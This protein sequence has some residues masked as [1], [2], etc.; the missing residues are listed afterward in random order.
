MGVVDAS[1]GGKV[2]LFLCVEL[3]VGVVLGGKFDDGFLRL[4][5]RLLLDELYVFFKHFN[6]FLNTVFFV[7]SL[8]ID[9]RRWGNIKVCISLIFIVFFPIKCF[10]GCETTKWKGI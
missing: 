10:V 6:V 7:H 5:E 2:I 4:I 9:G 8:A 3:G 1:K